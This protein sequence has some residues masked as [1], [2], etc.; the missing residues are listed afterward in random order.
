MKQKYNVKC[1]SSVDHI[2]QKNF[3]FSIG[4]LAINIFPRLQLISRGWWQTD[5]IGQR[6]IWQKWTRNS[7]TPYPTVCTTIP[8]QIS[9]PNQSPGWS[10]GILNYPHILTIYCI[11]T[12][13]KPSELKY[14]IHSFSSKNYPTSSTAWFPWSLDPNPLHFMTFLLPASDQEDPLSARTVTAC[15]VIK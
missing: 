3:R 1:L 7:I 10:P 14:T 5:G 6:R 8:R 9:K 2:S 4:S 12:E 11:V 15:C 13:M